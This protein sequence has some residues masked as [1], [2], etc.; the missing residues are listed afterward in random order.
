MKLAALISGGKDSLYATYLAKKDGNSIDYVIGFI[1]ENKESYMFHTPN[2]HL[3]KDIA[4]LMDIEYIEVHTKG[5]KE[6]ELI[7][8]ENALKALDI[9]GIVCGA[10]ASKYQQSRV[11]KICDKL[12]LKLIAPLWQRNNTQLL[13]DMLKDKFDIMIVAVAG[14]DAFDDKW[15][16]KIITTDIVKDLEALQKKHG[17]SPLGE[18]G[19]L[20]TLVINCPLYKE[21]LDVSIGNKH[22][23]SDTQSGWVEVK[24]P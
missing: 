4:E 20:E 13:K 22:W 17:I 18:G 23:E 5:R 21:K 14:G 2:I 3:V 6:E 11:K 8:I 15:L 12:G 10:V 7:D 24:K 19:E 16:G 9:D 1:S